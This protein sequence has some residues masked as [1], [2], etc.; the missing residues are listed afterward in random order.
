MCCEGRTKTEKPKTGPHY[1]ALA[2]DSFGLKVSLT[3]ESIKDAIVI[4]YSESPPSPSEDGLCLE[5][6]RIL[7]VANHKSVQ[8]MENCHDKEVVLCVYE[9][10]PEEV[11]LYAAFLDDN[12]PRKVVMLSQE[13]TNGTLIVRVMK[14]R[15]LVLVLTEEDDNDTEF[16]GDETDVLSRSSNMPS[17]SEI[18]NESQ[19]LDQTLPSNLNQSAD[20]DGYTLNIV[21]ERSFSLDEK[22]VNIEKAKFSDYILLLCGTSQGNFLPLKI[23]ERKVT[24][25]FEEHRGQSLCGNPLVSSVCQ[26]NY[27]FSITNEGEVLVS[28]KFGR[29]CHKFDLPPQWSGHTLVYTHIQSLSLQW[30]NRFSKKVFRAQ[31]FKFDGHRLLV[32][33]FIMRDTRIEAFMGLFQTRTAESTSVPLTGILKFPMGTGMITA[34]SFGPYDNCFIIVGHDSGLISIV[35]PLG[36]SLLAQVR[37]KSESPV[38]SFTFEPTKAILASFAD[39]S[40]EVFSP[41]RLT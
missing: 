29:Q 11:L 14:F 18:D 24:L 34:I 3:F 13:A 33:G 40:V 6:R 19:H 12:D 27:V 38:K 9:V 30:S 4:D 5:V 31:R 8:I 10:Q 25:Q 39:G 20:G 26:G 15:R 22:I 32:A 2:D 37:F 17:R 23:M 16:N 28:H 36:L 21:A 35:D 7:L 1:F 41:T